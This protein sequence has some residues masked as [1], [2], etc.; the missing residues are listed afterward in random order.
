MHVVQRCHL[1]LPVGLFV[2]R[3]RHHQGSPAGLQISI[4]HVHAELDHHPRPLTFKSSIN[5]STTLFFGASDLAL[6]LTMCA[7]QMFVLLL[8]LLLLLFQA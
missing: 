8:L 7:L 6:M 1:Y 3:Q 5:Q 2:Y 4:I